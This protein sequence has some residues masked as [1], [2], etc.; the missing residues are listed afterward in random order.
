LAGQPQGVRALTAA[1]V[2]RPSGR[3]IADQGNQILVG[4]GDEQLLGACAYLV[5]RR[6]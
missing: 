5:D 6:F 1:E 2:D 3:K 4:L